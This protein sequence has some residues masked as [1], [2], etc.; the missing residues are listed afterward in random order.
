MRARLLQVQQSDKPRELEQG[1]FLKFKHRET[2]M[3]SPFDTVIVVQRILGFLSIQTRY[4]TCDDNGYSA[5]G[6][7]GTKLGSLVRDEV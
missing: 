3:T 1:I 7:K 4:L 5:E 6:E 2:D